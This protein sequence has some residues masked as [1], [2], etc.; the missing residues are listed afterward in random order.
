[1]FEFTSGCEELYDVQFLPG[2]H[3]PMILNL[4]KP[5][6]RQAITNPESSFWL[7]ASSEIRDTE[8]PA[9]GAVGGH[10]LPVSS[11]DGTSAMEPA[12]NVLP[13]SGTQL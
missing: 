7:R 8:D 13:D 9:A 5:A 4:E 2:V 3:R 12:G 10:A 6:V 1:M 11:E